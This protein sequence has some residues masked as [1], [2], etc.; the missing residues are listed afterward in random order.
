MNEAQQR[1][2]EAEKQVEEFRSWAPAVQERYEA[3]PD[4]FNSWYKGVEGQ[5]N[6]AP[7]NALDPAYRQLEQQSIEIKRL[8]MERDLDNLAASGLE[9]TRDMR[10]EVAREV[11]VS[12]IEDVEAVYKKLYFDRAQAQARENAVSDTADR[13]NRGRQY[14]APPAGNASPQA[15]VDISKLSK[16]EKRSLA[17]ERIQDMPFY[18]E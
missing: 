15:P 18:N 7:P 10:Q 13:M 16:D 14:N 8:K 12:G 1:A 6:Q 4:G 3:D 9:M 17:M 5:P 11:Y 2:A